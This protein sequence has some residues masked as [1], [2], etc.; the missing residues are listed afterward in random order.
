MRSPGRVPDYPLPR[1]AA[2]ARFAVLRRRVAEQEAR[3]SREP[4][5]ELWAERD[6]WAEEAAAIAEA[7]DTLDRVL[8]SL[9]RC[10]CGKVAH[11]E[12]STAERHRRLLLTVAEAGKAE[13]GPVD[14]YACRQRRGE[15]LPAYH[16]GHRRFALVVPETFPAEE[17]AT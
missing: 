5:P 2:E 7:L 15:A 3:L 8:P 16:V 13:P 14:V 1:K 6:G 4:S 10:G 12:R 9:P 17:A 11:V